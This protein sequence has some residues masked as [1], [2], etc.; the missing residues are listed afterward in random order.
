MRLDLDRVGMTAQAVVFLEERDVMLRLEQPRADRTRRTPADN[1]Y[2][3]RS[4]VRKMA[5]GSF[6]RLAVAEVTLPIES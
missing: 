1:A 2:S 4:P 6:C 5:M 3:H